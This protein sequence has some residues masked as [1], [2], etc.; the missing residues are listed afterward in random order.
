MALY[1]D[2]GN[3][4]TKLEKELLEKNRLLNERLEA[5]NLINEQLIKKLSIC[6]VVSSKITN[7]QKQKAYDSAVKLVNEIFDW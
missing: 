2:L 3:D 4:Y 6:G 7:E 1:F 5:Q